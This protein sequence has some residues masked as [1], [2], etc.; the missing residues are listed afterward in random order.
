MMK[1]II[2]AVIVLIIGA[3]SFYGGVVY[4]K[5]SQPQ[6]NVGINARFQQGG[7]MNGVG[8]GARGNAN[9]GAVN[10]EILSKDDKSIT[11]KLRNGGSKIVFISASTKV[12]KSVEGALSDVSVGQQVMILGEDNSDGSI[13]AQSVQ[14]RPSQIVP[15][16]RAR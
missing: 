2:F 15:Q 10:G 14:I 3:G 12:A 7:V 9:S 5:K 11:V 13:S 1:N 6:R 4:A 8:S 16:D